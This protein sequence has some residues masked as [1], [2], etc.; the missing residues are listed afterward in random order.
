MIRTL[1]VNEVGLM[2]SVMASI[3]D[4]QGDIQVVASVVREQE[5]L[6][7]VRRKE[8]DIVLVSPRLPDGGT[9]R[10]IQAIYDFDPGVKSLVV[11]LSENQENVLRKVEAGASGY[12]ARDSSVKDLVAAIRLAH[13]GKANVS[14]EIMSALIQRVS[15]FARLFSSL[16]SSVMHNANLTPRELEILALLG[17]GL[18]NDEIGARLYIENGTVKNHVHSILNKLQVNTRQEAAAYLALLDKPTYHAGVMLGS[19]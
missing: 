1:I 10:L 6:D 17:Q 19:E 7:Y 5:A 3:F 16:E 18:T 2:G 4:D 13:D 11:G 12:V 15:E 8:V 14:P 9:L